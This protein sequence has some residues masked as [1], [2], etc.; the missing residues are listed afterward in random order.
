MDRGLGHAPMTQTGMR[1]RCTGRGS[2]VMGSNW[3]CSPWKANGSPLEKL[4]RMAR[5]SSRSAAR[6]LTPVSSPTLPNPAFVERAEADGQ[7]QATAGEMV[8]GERLAVQLP[9]AGAA[10][11]RRR[12]RR[13]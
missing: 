7:H 9:P 6:A 2:M 8:D 10:S 1:G 3:K 5:L 12:S 4:S 11:V 13:G